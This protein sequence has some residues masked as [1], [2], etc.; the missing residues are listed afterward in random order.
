MQRSMRRLA[1]GAISADEHELVRA[2]ADA[3]FFKERTWRRIF[4][5]VSPDID[6]AAE[7]LKPHIRNIK[8]EDAEA[9][10]DVLLER[11][12]SAPVGEV[13]PDFAGWQFNET[14]QWRKLRV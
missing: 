13:A 6:H 14:S 5:A 12:S 10:L 2:K 3:V 1:A 8:R 7:R 4:D 9:L 11:K